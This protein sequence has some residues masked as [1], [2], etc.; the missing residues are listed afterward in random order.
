MPQPLVFARTPLEV[1]RPLV[2]NTASIT[3]NQFTEHY[4]VTL[5]LIHIKVHTACQ[6]SVTAYNIR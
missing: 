5:L 1:V 3:S 4:F 2:A 6:H